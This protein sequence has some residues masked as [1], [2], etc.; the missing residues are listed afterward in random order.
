VNTGLAGGYILAS[1]G[2]DLFGTTDDFTFAARNI[3]QNAEI[4]T[5]INSLT[6]TN[7]Q[8]KAGLCMRTTLAP[9]A[10]MV[11]V[12]VTPTNQVYFMHRTTTADTTIVALNIQKGSAQPTN[13]AHWLKLRRINNTFEAYYSIDN[14]NWEAL[15]SVNINSFAQNYLIGL[16]TTANASS[17]TTAVFDNVSIA[18]CLDGNANQPIFGSDITN[19]SK[20]NNAFDLANYPNPFKQITTINFKIPEKSD[21]TLTITDIYGKSIANLLTDKLTEGFY[22]IPYNAAALSSGTYIIQL[23]VGKSVAYKRMVVSK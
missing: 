4:V 19:N 16:G 3:S 10:P 18:K 7:A 17:T 13:M 5:K 2:N 23:T 8:A 11:F 12:G 22:E 1:T 14:S 21:V 20:D 9:D 15:G 6:Y